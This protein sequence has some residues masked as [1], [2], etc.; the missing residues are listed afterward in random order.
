MSADHPGPPAETAPDL[1]DRHRAETRQIGRWLYEVQLIT[2]SATTL[3]GGNPFSIDMCLQQP[4]VVI[5]RRWAESKARR[6]LAAAYRDDARKAAT[7][8]IR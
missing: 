8:V 4:P 3:P 5:G 7:E 6:M 2:S 1:A